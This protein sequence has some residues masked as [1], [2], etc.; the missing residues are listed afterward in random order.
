MVI[1]RS[2]LHNYT[3]NSEH[4][5]QCFLVVQPLQEPRV[6]NTFLQWPTTHTASSQEDPMD[7]ILGLFR[8]MDDICS[9][10]DF[11]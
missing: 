1:E 5:A 10:K 3:P 9:K 11:R 6:L 4:F 8:L 7:V 2:I